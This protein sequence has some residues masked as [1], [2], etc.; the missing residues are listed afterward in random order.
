LSNPGAQNFD[1]SVSKRVALGT[2]GRG[3]QCIGFNFLN[4]ANWN[5]PD[6]TIGPA[7]APNVNAGR[8]IGSRGGRVVQMGFEV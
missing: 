8:I 6:P 3:V 4:H 7:S 2:N 1:V 5:D